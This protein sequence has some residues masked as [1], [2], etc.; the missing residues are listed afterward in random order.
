MPHRI[1]W[2]TPQS[3]AVPA[4]G[5]VILLDAS[6]APVVSQ[7]GDALPGYRAY[8]R[9]SRELPQATEAPER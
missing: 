7:Y 9:C 5:I 8:T 6:A 4:G 3:S 2:L 1:V